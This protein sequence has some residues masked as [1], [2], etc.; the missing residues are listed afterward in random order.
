MASAMPNFYPSLHTSVGATVI[1]V[2]WNSTGSTGLFS[3]QR[4][5]LSPFWIAKTGPA[6]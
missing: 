6:T 2:Y 4:K 5:K 3:N 1:L